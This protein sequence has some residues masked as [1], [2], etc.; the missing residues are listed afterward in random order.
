MQDGAELI[1]IHNISVVNQQKYLTSD[2]VDYIWTSRLYIDEWKNLF[3]MEY[4]N[5]LN[6]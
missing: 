4:L 2:N 6:I 3:S 5:I 1:V